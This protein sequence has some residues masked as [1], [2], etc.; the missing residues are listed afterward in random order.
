[1]RE[2]SLLHRKK[3]PSAFKPLLFGLIFILTLV[4]GL[5]FFSSFLR[6]SAIALLQPLW[7]AERVVSSTASTAPES[8]SSKAELIEELSVLRLRLAKSDIVLRRFG[9][10]EEENVHLKELL[11]RQ[12]YESAVLA[13]VLGRPP[14]TPYDTLLIDLGQEVAGVGDRVTVEGSIVIGTISE[15]YKGTAQVLL[16]SAPGVETEALVG[17][18]RIPVRARGQGGGSFVAEF[19]RDAVVQEGDAVVLPGVN[20]YLFATVMSTEATASNPF[21]T[22]RF[23]NPINLQSIVWVQVIT[24]PL[25]AAAVEDFVPLTSS[26]TE[27]STSASE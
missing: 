15:V 25:E 20:P 14:Q 5:F 17:P 9:V 13:S 16:F 7:K 11:G 2:Y 19:P 1:M 3:A 8:F 18:L 12:L 26:T 21:I 6:E 23:K 24:N 27:T 22:I 10:L 4:G